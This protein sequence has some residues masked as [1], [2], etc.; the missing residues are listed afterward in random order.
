MRRV[1][2]GINASPGIAIGRAFILSRTLQRVERKTIP[3]KR[4]PKQVKAFLSAIKKSM[5]EIET[6][7]ARLGA[8]KA[9]ELSTVLDTH[10]MLLQD[11]ALRNDVIKIIEEQKVTASWAVSEHV[12]RFNKMLANL[13][14]EYLS[15]RV[16]DLNDI[17]NRI[18]RNLGPGGGICCLDEAPEGSVV[19]A[20]DINPSEAVQINT[21][22]IVGFVT[23]LGSKTSHS[24]IIAKAHEIPAVVGATGVLQ[25]VKQGTRMIVD[26]IDGKVI[27]SPTRKQLAEYENKRQSYKYYVIELLSAADLPAESR[28]GFRLA[29]EA[30]IESPA[31]VK[32]ALRHGA[33]GI[34][35]YRTEYLFIRE[36]RIPTQ[37]EHLASY[38]QVAE[39]IA[40]H[41][42]TIRTIDIGG[43][44]LVDAVE[45]PPQRNPALGLRAIRLCFS[46]REIFKNQIKGILRAGLHGNLKI[47]F[48]M[49]S[50]IEEL[51]KGKA[52][53]EECKKEL[54]KAHVDFNADMEVGIMIEIPSAALTADILAPECDFFSIG[55]N[56]LIQYSIAIDRANE[57]VAYLYNPLHPAVLRTIKMVVEAGHRH[58]V[59]VGVCGEMAGEP[60]YA[61]MLMGLGVDELSMNPVAIPAVKKVIRSSRLCESLKIAS[62]A[63]GF[64]TADEIEAYIYN[65][66]SKRYPQEI[67]TS[68]FF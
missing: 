33:A 64:Q 21:A 65:V 51:K 9:K 34:G 60:L 4:V 23:E 31:D 48:P 37:E 68:L 35:L 7:R 16:A 55:T 1:F 32:T 38:K 26:G 43:E 45:M 20:Q 46:R 24:A 11:D 59:R 2:T 41:S 40:P 52:I 57:E 10:I 54:R 27:L 14:G 13:G 61:L 49:I 17:K 3:E 66:M 22:R 28:D 19:V 36:G 6:I 58:K 15:T 8:D 42:A 39:E 29:I 47:M 50:G 25:N 63:L 56:D 5:K 44:K 12:G 18:L 62:K 67:A 53:I 30:N